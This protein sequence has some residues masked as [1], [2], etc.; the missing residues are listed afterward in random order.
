MCVCVRE[1]MCEG[2]CVKTE[3]SGVVTDTL[4]RL[5]V[6]LPSLESG[7]DKRDCVGMLAGWGVGGRHRQIE[8]DC[9]CAVTATLTLHVDWLPC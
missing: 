7:S 3:A 1:S 6:L 9:F 2:M 4:C 8:G 5:T